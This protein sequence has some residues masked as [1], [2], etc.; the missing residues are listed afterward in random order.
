MGYTPYPQ[1]IKIDS[2]NLREVPDNWTPIRLRFVVESNPVKSE[3]NF[4]P[5]DTLVSFVPME[6]VSETGSMS[7]EKEK[8]LADV[9]NGYTFFRNDDV[10][11]AKITPCF[12]NGKGAVASNLTNGIG[13][14]TTEFHV[15]RKI[16]GTDNRWLFYITKSDTFRKYGESEMYGAGGQKRVPD[17][18]IKNF[19]VGFPSL[20]E[21][22]QI[23]NFL[24]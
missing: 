21:Q 12:E 8:P 10:V 22:T 2:I 11:L 7:L 18:F 5:K 13:F 1:Y 4:L 23:A 17:S 15:L 9:Y 19:M 14:G 24:D 20:K 3:I 16:E 6:A